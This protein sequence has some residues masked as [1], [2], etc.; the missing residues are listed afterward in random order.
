[1]KYNL[2]VIGMILTTGCGGYYVTDNSPTPD[3][4]LPPVGEINTEDNAVVRARAVL[5]VSSEQPSL[6][7]KFFNKLLPN[8]YAALASTT[9]TYT[10]AAAVNFTI[11]TAGLV[12]GSVTGTILSLGSI[13]MSGVDD[14]HLK[15]CNPGGNTKC[16]QAVIRMYNTG[17]TAGL[18]HADGYAI[19]VYAGT[20]NPSTALGLNVAGSVQVQNYTIPGNR[21]RVRL[22]NFASP[23]YAV[24]TDLEN[25]GSG[26]FSM[27]LV[28]EYVLLP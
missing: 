17:S 2:A 28:V 16:T 5:N 6:L 3:I 27:V 20:L 4:N 13:T 19:P 23:T 8:A 18:V 21:N 11:S 24:T 26:S 9:V 14:N 25:A 1:M 22:S 7:T 15:V 12:Q 10:N